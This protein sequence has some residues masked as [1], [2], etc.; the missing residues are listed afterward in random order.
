MIVTAALYLYIV[1]HLLVKFVIS[2]PWRDRRARQRLGDFVFPTGAEWDDLIER[3]KN[4][5][6]E[7]VEIVHWEND[8]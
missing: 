3:A 5:K 6:F 8:E 7:R 1:F 2:P 4:Y